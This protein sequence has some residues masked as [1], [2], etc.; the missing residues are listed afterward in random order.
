MRSAL[1]AEHLHTQLI[2]TAVISSH[3]GDE[4]AKRDTAMTL[5][6]ASAVPASKKNSPKKR[7][8]FSRRMI[9]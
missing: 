5:A 4:R 9:L 2:A 1:A 3:S 8:S 6:S 7:E